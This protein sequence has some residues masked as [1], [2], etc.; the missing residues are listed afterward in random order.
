M[1]ALLCIDIG[2]SSAHAGIV[3]NGTILSR[4]DTPTRRFVTAHVSAREVLEKARGLDGVAFASVV[5]AAAEGLKLLLSEMGMSEKGYHLRY[6]TASFIGFDYPRPAEIG[7]D[8]IANV[9]AARHL[10]GTPA[11]VI[12][13]G[14]ATTF[15]VLTS[16]G[17]SGGIISPGLALMTDYLHEKTALLPRLERMELASNSSI[18][19][20]TEEA[21]KIGAHIGFRGMIGEMLRCVIADLHTL[22]EGPASVITTGGNAALLPSGWWPG[23]R[24]VPD[25]AL[26]GLEIAF[27]K[28]RS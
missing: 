8:R 9:I 4:S 20:S 3:D 21:M 13:M 15:D 28:A 23:A 7:Q 27:N 5:P 24:H 1:A 6:D 17:Y 14:T 22:G 12:D 16:K 2:N 10:V 26:L 25:L 19:K 11:V 18:G